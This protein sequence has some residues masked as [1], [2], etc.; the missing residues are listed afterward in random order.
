MVNTVCETGG[1][2]HVH[3][4]KTVNYRNGLNINKEWITVGSETVL[5][6]ITR[7]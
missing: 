4:C 6:N 3:W 1:F 7:N 5:E 2:R